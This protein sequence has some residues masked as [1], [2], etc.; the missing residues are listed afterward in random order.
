MLK[1]QNKAIANLVIECLCEWF[2]RT[3]TFYNIYLS[4]IIFLLL[5]R[6]T[7]ME[8]VLCPVGIYTREIRRIE[9]ELHTAK[10]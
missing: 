2:S 10:I 9:V 6:V 3:V 8:A 5:S 7:V 1:F 4:Y